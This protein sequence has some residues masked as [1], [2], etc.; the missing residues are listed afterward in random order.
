[1]SEAILAPGLGFIGIRRGLLLPQFQTV[2]RLLVEQ[3]GR[4][5][6]TGIERV[7]FSNDGWAVRDVTRIMRWMSTAP[8]TVVHDCGGNLLDPPPLT[9]ESM[10]SWADFS[11]ESSSIPEWNRAIVDGSQ[12]LLACPPV[13]VEEARSRT[14]AAVRYARQVGKSAIVVLPDGTVETGGTQYF[15]TSDG[16]GEKKLSVFIGRNPQ[17]DRFNGLRA[18]P[19]LLELLELD[20][21][22]GAPRPVLGRSKQNARYFREFSSLKLMAKAGFRPAGAYRICDTWQDY[23]FPWLDVAP[24][25]DAESDCA[26]ETNSEGRFLKSNAEVACLVPQ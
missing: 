5:A 22:E 13:M 16:V 6:F 17:A 19:V 21:R 23:H 2:C 24:S 18:Q 3:R 9:I 8:R 26:I 15:L 7:H 4:G 11:V 1:M 20:K 14:W 10:A 12:A 25:S